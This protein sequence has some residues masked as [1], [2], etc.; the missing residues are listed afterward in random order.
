MPDNDDAGVNNHPKA[1]HPQPILQC[2]IT[3]MSDNTVNVNGFPTSLL[4]VFDLFFAAFK[5]VIMVFIARAKEGS[6]DD[7]NNIIPK[8]IIQQD[9]RLADPDGRPVQ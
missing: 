6:L 5:A 2:R 7:Q 4:A 1:A 3:A 8:K 9:K